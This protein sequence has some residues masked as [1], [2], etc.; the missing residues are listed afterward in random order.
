MSIELKFPITKSQHNIIVSANQE[1]EQLRMAL[2]FAEK[3]RDKALSSILA[4]DEV[5]FAKKIS[6]KS[7][8]EGFISYTLDEEAP[9]PEAPKL[10]KVD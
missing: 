10:E 2:S 6:I 8:A 7:F 5:L 3:A 9:A 1:V 4:S